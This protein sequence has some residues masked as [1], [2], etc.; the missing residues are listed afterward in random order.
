MLAS[1]TKNNLPP[2]IG[3]LFP[4]F[5]YR[6]SGTVRLRVHLSYCIIMLHAQCKYSLVKNMFIYQKSLSIGQAFLIV[7]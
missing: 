5:S 7:C 3:F 6:H 4:V 1:V 2:R